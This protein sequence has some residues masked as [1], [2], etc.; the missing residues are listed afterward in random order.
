M[1]SLFNPRTERWDQ[2]FR[3]D[4]GIVTPL[5]DTGEV[6]ARLLRFNLAERVV[7]RVALQSA[8]RYPSHF[9]SRKPPF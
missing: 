3:L 6:T 8:G 5:T 7:E 1:I 9:L 2:H 4:G